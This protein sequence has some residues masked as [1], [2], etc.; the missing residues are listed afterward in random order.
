M[1]VAQVHDP[2]SACLVARL[3]RDAGLHPWVF[4]DRWLTVPRLLIDVPASEFHRARW[5]LEVAEVS[6]AE[7]VY[8]ATGEFSGPV[9]IERY[10]APPRARVGLARGVRGFTAGITLASLAAVLL[11]TLER[12]WASALVAGL[13][14]WGVV[15]I[16][17]RS[18][19]AA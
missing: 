4:G 14:A 11:A 12:F 16:A 13:I 9:T 3:L 19:R 5:F 10:P 15:A 18:Q 6:D 8:L 1:V 7:L 17:G 2:I